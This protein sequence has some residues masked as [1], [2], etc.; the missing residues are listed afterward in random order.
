LKWLRNIQNVESITAIT[1]DHAMKSTIESDSDLKL[2]PCDKVL[3]GNWMDETFC[4]S[5]MQE[6]GKYD[7]IIADY[8]V[9]AVDGF[10]PY[11]QELVLG[12]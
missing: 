11:C 8:L 9:G 5:L 10:S 4:A 2:R 6:T 1:A 7:T 12:K 3:V